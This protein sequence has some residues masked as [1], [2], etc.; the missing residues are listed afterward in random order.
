MEN[1]IKQ[2]LI[3]ENER[4]RLMEYHDT[5]IRTF[6]IIMNLKYENL[7][8]EDKYNTYIN[9]ITI[10]FPMLINIK[11]QIEEKYGETFDELYYSK[12]KSDI[13]DLYL[14]K[15]D[16]H[17]NKF[18]KCCNITIDNAIRILDELSLLKMFSLNPDFL[19]DIE[20]E[21]DVLHDKIEYIEEVYCN[22]NI[23]EEYEEFMEE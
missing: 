20:K 7:I 17:I 9:F 11:S 18:Q 3:Y 4:N 5:I 14:I 16:E 13:K 19:S 22:F 2:M 10:D 8:K 12:E 21:F 23:Q 15:Y 1:I 6:N